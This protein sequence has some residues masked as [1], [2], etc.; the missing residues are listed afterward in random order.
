MGLYTGILYPDH[1]QGGNDKYTVL[2]RVCP[3]TT[4]WILEN[5]L[6]KARS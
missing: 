1:I 6:P 3:F 2:G 4:W 5:N